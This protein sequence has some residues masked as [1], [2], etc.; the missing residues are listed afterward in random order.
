MTKLAAQ[1][2]SK[3]YGGLRVLNGV[4]L[5]IRE[6][7]VTALIGPNG[8][9]KTTLANIITGF[10]TPDAGQIIFSGRDITRLGVHHRTQLGMGRTFQ[11]L[12]LFSDLSVRENVVLGRYRKFRRPAWMCS[13]SAQDYAEADASIERMGLT[14]C[15]QREAGALSFGQSKMLELARLHVMKPGLIIMDEPAAG[16]PGD[17]T[18][19]LAKWI[20]S[21]TG[22]G[23]GMMLIEHNM[24]LVMD[25]AD[26]VYV[27]DH[28]QMIAEGPPHVIRENPLVLKA[29]L[30]VPAGAD[31]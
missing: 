21:M 25:V 16:L 2:I 9:G 28:G 22:Q 3:A 24:R 27:L 17:R 14:D 10:G 31:T 30:G 23:I 19:E 1:N 8:A 6:G 11:N 18:A 13:P 15:A 29:Y 12:Q 20:R 7:Q 5:E 26:Y 4:N